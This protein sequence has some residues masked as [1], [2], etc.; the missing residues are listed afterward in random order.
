M[1]SR[2]GVGMH[3]EDQT[4]HHSKKIDEKQAAIIIQRTVRHWLRNTQ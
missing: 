3:S 2:R 1:N 4:S